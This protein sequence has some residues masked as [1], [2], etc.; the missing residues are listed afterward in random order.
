MWK[1]LTSLS[2]DFNLDFAKLH[3]FAVLH[4]AKYKTAY[5]QKELLINARFVEQ[6]INDF[7]KVNP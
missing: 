3:D 4:K 5:Y 2:E 7:K 6:F 1:T